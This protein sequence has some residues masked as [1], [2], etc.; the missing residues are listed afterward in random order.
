MIPPDILNLAATRILQLILK[1]IAEGRDIEGKAYQYSTKTF[2]R[3][4]GNSLIPGGKFKDAEKA[5]D[6]TLFKTKAGKLWMLIHGGY[7]KY[8]ELAGRST[9]GDFLN[10]SGN[11]LAAMTAR[12][13]G[14]LI[15]VGFSSQGES[16][17]AF[18]LNI[19]GAGRSHRLWKFFG[20]NKQNME[21]VARE[22]G[23]QYAASPQFIS[24]ISKLFS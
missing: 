24:E 9:E 12:V 4:A 6:I 1:Q 23:S 2:A 21:A 18:Y 13:N 8:R 16:E 14:N 19:S 5:G 11:M 20:L 15:N 7:K 10:F 17:K 3:P 22:F